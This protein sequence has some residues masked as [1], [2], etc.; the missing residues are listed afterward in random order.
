[1]A[2]SAFREIDILE[3]KRIDLEGICLRILL[4]ITRCFS[5]VVALISGMVH[6]PFEPISL[7]PCTRCTPHSGHD[8]TME[9][10]GVNGMLSSG[11][12]PS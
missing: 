9:R 4:A 10:Y 8:R 3:N 6:V 1:M 11:Q 2:K 5:T 7:L 12:D